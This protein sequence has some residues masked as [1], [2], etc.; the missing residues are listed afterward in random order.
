[1]P[2]D[3]EQ[4]REFAAGPL[5]FSAALRA[6]EEAAARRFGKPG[7][8]VA[9][10]PDGSAKAMEKHLEI[11]VEGDRATASLGDA[12]MPLQLRRIDGRW[13]VDLADATRDPRARRAGEAAA[14]AAAAKVAEDVAGEIAE[15]KYETAE[16]AKAAFRER[17]LAQAKT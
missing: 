10:H 12:M 8:Q 14:A 9:G 6:L 7:R 2:V 1:M 13:R 11:K 16:A 15:G 17:R 4:Q 3:D 5:R